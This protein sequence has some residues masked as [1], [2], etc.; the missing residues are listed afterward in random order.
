MSMAAS[1]TSTISLAYDGYWREPGVWSIPNASGVYSVYACTYN[2]AENTVWIR[3]LL[4]IGESNGV[5][6]RIRQHLSSAT[7]QS[8]KTHLLAGE[9]LCF[10]FA[11]ISS[12]TRERAEAALIYRHKPP[13]NTEHAY[14]FPWRWS[15]TTVT[16]SGQNVHLI[17]HF[18]VYSS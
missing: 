2:P 6:D 3:R 10:A 15:P 11:P 13:E 16:T 12:A 4:Y 5:R 17:P 7:G 9:V 18:T 1:T 8:W 14:S